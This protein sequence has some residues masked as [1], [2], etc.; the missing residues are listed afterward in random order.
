MKKII[1][2]LT[3]TWLSLIIIAWC[4][5]KNRIQAGDLVSITYTAT[6]SD[7]EIFDQNTQKTP[8]MFTV[9]SHQVIQWLDDAVIGMKV[10]KKK[11]V[12]IS[13]EDWYGPL[14][15]ATLVQKVGKLIFDKLGIAPK[16]GSTQ[17]LDQ[18]EWVIKGIETDGS[19]NEFILF[20]INPRQTWDTLTYKIT[21]L[22]K[23]Q[24]IEK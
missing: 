8:L 1:T 2:F 23:E 10:G 6:F 4:S 12:T 17:K 18:L 3:I 15:N 5:D 22:A 24:P 16:V 21:V 13:P 20:D 14:Y 7:W 11:T 9:G 19:G